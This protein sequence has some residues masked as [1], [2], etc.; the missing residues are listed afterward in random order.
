MFFIL[1]GVGSFLLRVCCVVTVVESE[2]VGGG[3]KHG[4]WCWYKGKI[5]LNR[6][7]TS[8]LGRR[9]RMSAWDVNIFTLRALVITNGVTLVVLRP[10]TSLER[11]EIAEENEWLVWESAGVSG[12]QRGDVQ[13]LPFYHTLFQHFSWSALLL[14]SSMSNSLESFMEILFQSYKI[15][16][17]FP[18]TLSV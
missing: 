8:S 5:N 15:F 2:K 9:W 3:G 18:L 17:A 1:V 11:H 10:V 16:L 14:F 6:T 12:S 13:V 7:M 4:D